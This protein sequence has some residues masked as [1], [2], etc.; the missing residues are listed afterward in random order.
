MTSPPLTTREYA[1]FH[2]TGLG[3]HEQVTEIL[4]IKPSKAW[5]EG[6]INPRNGMPYKFMRWH[7]SSG[8][9]DT[10]PLEMHIQSLFALLQPKADALRQL[11]VEYNLTLQCVGHFPPSGHGMYFDRE[12]IR[13]AAQLGLCFDL[14]FYYVDDYGH[15]V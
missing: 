9:D 10:Q 8:L 2:I 1:Y 12:Q 14:D 15:H 3:T 7:L 6:D 11:W 13:Q 5:N 4:K